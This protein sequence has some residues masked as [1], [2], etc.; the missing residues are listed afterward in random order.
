MSEC[1]RD[2]G[3]CTVFAGGCGAHAIGSSEGCQV[4]RG[5]RRGRKEGIAEGRALERK[6][7]AAWLKRD[8]SAAAQDSLWPLA[9]DIERGEHVRGKGER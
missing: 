3:E 5:W 8:A 1:V 7:V 6:D 4:C 9:N 2:Y